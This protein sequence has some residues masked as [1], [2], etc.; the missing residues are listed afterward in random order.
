M[1][2][3]TLVLAAIAFAAIYGLV[4]YGP[5]YVPAL[6]VVNTLPGVSQ[7]QPGV[8][9]F[10]TSAQRQLP[11][12]TAQTKVLGV[13]TSNVLQSLPNPG[14]EKARYDYC[15]EVVRVYEKN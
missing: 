11:G 2:I 5:R 3:K 6:A 8:E 14:F 10:I 9:N 15:K 4:T 7:I 12:V 13:H 1:M